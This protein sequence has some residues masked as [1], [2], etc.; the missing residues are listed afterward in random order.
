M[1]QYV[2]KL[3]LF[4]FL[5]IG[6]IN[7]AQEVE[8]SGTTDEQLAAYYY[9]QGEFEK[10]ILYYE[11]LYTTRP[12]DDYYQYYLNCLLALEDFKNAEKLTEKQIKLSPQTLRY[13]VDL[14]KIYE[15]SGES[16]KAV[17]HFDKM[18]KEL[19]KA[20]INQ[21]IDLGNAFSEMNANDRAL[22]VFY[23]GRKMMGDSYPFHFQI[24]QVLGQKGDIEGMI[25]EYLDVLL[26]SKGYL[27]SV[28]NTLNRVI[29]FEEQN[30]YNAVL[31]QA[32]MTRVQ[33]SPDDDI[34]AQMLVW[35]L[36][37]QNRFDAAL[38]HVKALDKRN[39][40]DGS[41]VMILARTALENFQYK[42]AVEAFGYV[43][44][45]GRDNYYY[46]EA[47]IG[48]LKSMKTQII[49]TSY[50][51]ESINQL[52]LAYQAALN[53][54]GNQ[55]SAWELAKD[56]AHVKAF[57][58]SRFRPGASN[59]AV[60]IL[61]EALNYPGLDERDLAAIKMELA[62][63]YVLTG[64]IWDAS[65]LYGQVEKRFKYD[66]IGFQA[67]LNN[68][69]V[70]Y[71][72]GD[73]GWAEAQLDVLK[74]STSKL[75]ANDAMELASFISENTGLDT[76]TEALATFA[77][78]ELYLAQHKYDSASYLFTLI[79]R[80]FPGHELADNIQFMRA[81]IAD[82]QGDYTTAAELYSKVADD[83]PNDILADNAL[84]EAGLIHEQRLNQSQE[85]MLIY[86]RILT[87]Y[88][89]SLFVVEARKRF[90]QLRGDQ[91]N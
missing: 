73:F 6:S 42:T 69:K 10:A 13:Q 68:A 21:I 76:T 59:E 28:Q 36:V 43:A 67:K 16:S 33:K 29:G 44:E 61:E 20:S 64:K 58:E 78:A 62:D 3:L 1:S 22:E 40:E 60:Q 19:D 87:D 85:A 63:I 90:R 89:S 81:Q 30:E 17:K 57:Y 75:I 25:N 48:K 39:R 47:V 70:F 56:L 86:E 34:Y 88:P 27:Q 72:S 4:T 83:Y 26:V 14:G 11:R 15:R 77:H 38:I 55:R 12:T 71:Y 41:R 74:G 66:E 45:K 49:N 8:I 65:L 2:S 53:E 79:E 50:Q 80:N 7:F 51:P 37:K 31:E 82:A 52:T 23:K 9:R 35:M 54:F 46:T 91:I 24:A 84:M 18:I 32:L 5:L